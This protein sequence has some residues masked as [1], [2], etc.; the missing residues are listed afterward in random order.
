M[1]S[2]Q[3]FEWIRNFVP[4]VFR[5]FVEIQSKFNWNY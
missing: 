1:T 5:N 2:P 4:N 3:L